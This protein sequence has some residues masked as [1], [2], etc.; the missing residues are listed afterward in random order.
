M[1]LNSIDTNKLSLQETEDSDE[2]DYSKTNSREE[3]WVEDND[4]LYRKIT[5]E[6][7]TRY[8]SEK[9]RNPE[10][11]TLKRLVTE[12]DSQ[13]DS[14]KLREIPVSKLDVLRAQKI[15]CFILKDNGKYFYTVVPNDLKL[16]GT[17][18]VEH[19]CAPRTAICKRMST[20]PDCDGGCR[21][22]RASSKHIEDYPWITA[23]Y[24]T[25]NT[26]IECFVVINCGHQDL[27]DVKGKKHEKVPGDVMLELASFLWNDVDSVG[28]LIERIEKNV[29]K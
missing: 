21:K 1:K 12:S 11:V 9:R 14:F 29:S 19:R 20:L 13:L 23:G 16:I 26:Q 15:P 3:I 8:Y 10:E 4:I 2:D 5:T 25:V 6:N 27:I 24:E 22:V 28:K 17:L 18:K 7:V